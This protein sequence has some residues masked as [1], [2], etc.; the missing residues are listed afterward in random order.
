[1]SQWHYQLKV[2]GHKDKFMVHV[3]QI[4]S[5]ALAIVKLH[6]SEGIS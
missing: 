3:K 2:M 4:K 6:L 1:M 5:G